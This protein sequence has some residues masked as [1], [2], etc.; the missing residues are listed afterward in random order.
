MDTQCLFLLPELK[1]R[2]KKKIKALKPY[3]KRRMR[4]K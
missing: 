2:G 1:T 4:G 3:P